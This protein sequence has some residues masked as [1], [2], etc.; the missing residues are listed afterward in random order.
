MVRRIDVP[1]S[2]RITCRKGE[3]QGRKRRTRHD[4]ERIIGLLK[5]L[6]SNRL[7]MERSATTNVSLFL[8]TMFFSSSSL[9]HS[10]SLSFFVYYTHI[11]TFCVNLYV[12]S[13][14]NRTNLAFYSS[15]SSSFLPLKTKKSI[16]FSFL[17]ACTTHTLLFKFIILCLYN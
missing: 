7:L 16:F 9:F 1:F 14:G 5:Q 12:R 10:F 11:I 3:I 4:I 2:R 13:S 15:S 6:Q 8:S 17:R